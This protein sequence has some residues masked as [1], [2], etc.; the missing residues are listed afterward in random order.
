MGDGQTTAHVNHHT[1]C[2]QSSQQPGELVAAQQRT[3]EVEPGRAPL[4][5]EGQVQHFFRT[6][7]ALLAMGE[8]WKK[9]QGS[10]G[11]DFE[12]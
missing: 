4:D 12:R 1:C 3:R 2:Y 10:H 9:G 8:D 6:S 11:E 5:V 7:S